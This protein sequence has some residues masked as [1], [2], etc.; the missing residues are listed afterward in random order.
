M[1]STAV[2]N[3]HL[4]LCPRLGSS[5]L[6]NDFAG[7][8]AAAVPQPQPSKNQPR[9]I[10][11]AP[12][13]SK[14]LNHHNEKLFPLITQCFLEDTQI[15]KSSLLA[16]ALGLGTVSQQSYFLRGAVATALRT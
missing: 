4:H 14:Q 16:L 10:D 6:R 13:L 11:T 9:R 2:V 5:S 12:P 15:F 7:Q 8:C 1:Q 3:H